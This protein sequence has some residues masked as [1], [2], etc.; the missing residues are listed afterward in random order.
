[1]ESSTEFSFEPRNLDRNFQEAGASMNRNLGRRFIKRIGPEQWNHSIYALFILFASQDGSV[2]Y[3]YCFPLCS[4][5]G[6]P[7]DNERNELVL[8]ECYLHN[9]FYFAAHFVCGNMILFCD[10][11]MY[12]DYTSFSFHTWLSVKIYNVISNPTTLTK[13]P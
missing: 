8:L 1:M 2:Y 12:R 13:T 3:H 7:F 10:T 4:V 9:W 5:T 6:W 11:I